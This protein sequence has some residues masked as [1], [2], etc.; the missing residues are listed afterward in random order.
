MRRR[1]ALRTVATAAA[2]LTLTACFPAR[3]DKNPGP[4]PVPIALDPC[5]KPEELLTEETRPTSGNRL[6]DVALPCLGGEGTVSMR[7]LGGKPTVVNLW[8]SWCFPCRTEMP[9]FQKVY[10]QYGDRVRFLGVDTKD[11]DKDARAAIQRAAISY[12]NVFDKEEKV[13]RSINARTLPATVIVGADGL[14][15]TVH[16]GELTA[17]D[18]RAELRKAGV[19]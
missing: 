13:R 14:I 15:K 4:D 6:P 1:T 11:F 8:A 19:T 2:F 7:A 3:N 18:L 9:E 12:P 17:D 10:K 5:P 16:I